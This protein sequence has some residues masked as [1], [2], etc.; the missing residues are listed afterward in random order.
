MERK[1]YRNPSLTVDILINCKSHN[2]EG[3]VLIKR[4][5]PPHGWAIPGGFVDYGEPVYQAAV[6]EAREETSLSVRLV[7]QF[8]V[9]SHPSRDPRQHIASVVFIAEAFGE[10]KAADDAKDIKIIPPEALVKF[11][12]ELVC[13][14]WNILRD[15]IYYIDSGE[16]PS[17]FIEDFRASLKS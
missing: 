3:I 10:P 1:E 2:E 11:K 8:F 7:E 12:G 6:R 17:P 14:H 5:N 13:D 9:Y 16:R 15:Y 4:K